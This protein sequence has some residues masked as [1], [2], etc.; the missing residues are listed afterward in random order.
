M[1]EEPSQRILELPDSARISDR[2]KVSFGTGETHGAVT[3]SSNTG[4]IRASR[5]KVGLF[6]LFVNHSV[7]LS[8]YSQ[9][10]I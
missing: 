1:P 4:F 3:I 5:Q 6:I 10:N 2:A 9:Y 7:K 8:E